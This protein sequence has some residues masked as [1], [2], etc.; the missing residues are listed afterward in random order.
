MEKMLQVPQFDYEGG[1][2]F[3]IVNPR[4]RLDLLSVSML[5]LND[6]TNGI[7][8]FDYFVDGISSCENKIHLGWF[9][10]NDLQ[11]LFQVHQFQMEGIVYLIED[12]DIKLP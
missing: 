4:L 1:K 2:A 12:K 7:G 9:A 5:H 6:L 3:L 10:S 8:Q 11:H